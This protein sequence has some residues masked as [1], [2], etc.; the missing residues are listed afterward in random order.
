MYS[1]TSRVKSSDGEDLAQLLFPIPTGIFYL[2]RSAIYMDAVSETLT[3]V[4]CNP[5]CISII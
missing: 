3:E 1:H 2:F 4:F 5:N